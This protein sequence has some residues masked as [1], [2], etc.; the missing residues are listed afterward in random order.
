MSEWGT[1]EGLTT[2]YTGKVTDA[3]FDEGQYGGTLKLTVESDD[4][5]S[6][7]TENWYGCGKGVAVISDQE[8]SLD[9][10]KGGKFNSASGVGSLIQHLL[11]DE[12]LIGQVSSKGG[13][14][15][16]SSY[17]GLEAVWELVE[18]ENT[19]NGEKVTYTRMLPVAVVG[20]GAGGDDGED[21]AV[22]K[23]LVNLCTESASYDTFVELALA[24]DQLTAEL[25]KLVMN[26]SYWDFS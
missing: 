12:R 14:D 9:N 4:L 24:D 11:K 7:E 13:P 17:I 20:E 16:A 15:K 19:I 3:Y 2:R 5:D 23:W 22:P 25:R 21:V 26:E 10:M 6:G 8:V 1:E 18:F